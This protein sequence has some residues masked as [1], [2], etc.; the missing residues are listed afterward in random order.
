MRHLHK[1]MTVAS[2]PGGLRAMTDDELRLWIRDRR[3]GF[4]A[5]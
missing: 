1:L 3:A 2:Q 5:R 4:G